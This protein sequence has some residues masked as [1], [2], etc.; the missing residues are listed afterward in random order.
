MTHHV[1]IDFGRCYAWPEAR[2]DEANGPLFVANG[3]VGPMRHVWL[4]RPGSRD[5][6]SVY[7]SLYVT[8]NIALYI[9]IYI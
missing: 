7:I 1:K 8:N 9:Y 4:T 3:V 5:R 2:S 6:L